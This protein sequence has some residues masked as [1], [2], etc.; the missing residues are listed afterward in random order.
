MK[1][2]KL[3]FPRV[4]IYQDK[5]T[6]LLEKICTEAPDLHKSISILL[7]LPNNQLASPG[8]PIRKRENLNWQQKVEKKGNN[9]R[10]GLHLKTNHSMLL[11]QKN[12]LTY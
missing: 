12:S 6:L 7:T 5:S 9:Y 11:T 4:Y 1:S 8:T 10:K 2:C 3:V